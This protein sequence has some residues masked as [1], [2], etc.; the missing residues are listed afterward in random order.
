[1]GSGAGEMSSIKEQTAA[2]YVL[3]ELLETGMELSAVAKLT[4]IRK[5]ELTAF[6]RAEAGSDLTPKE[7]DKLGLL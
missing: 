7:I 4:G 5:T 1:M 6:Y 2:R 3:I